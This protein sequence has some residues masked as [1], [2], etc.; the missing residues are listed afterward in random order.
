MWIPTC[1]SNNTTV[2]QG[3]FSIPW[4]T[5]VE[6]HSYSAL[7]AELCDLYVTRRRI[8]SGFVRR[9]DSPFLFNY[10]GEPLLFSSLY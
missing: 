4:V 8:I 3:E 2:V 7:T 6:Y 5:A 1:Y 9:G 10:D